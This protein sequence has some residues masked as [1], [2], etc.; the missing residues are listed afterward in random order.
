MGSGNESEV[1][2]VMLDKPAYFKK[3]ILLSIQSVFF[4][5]CCFWDL[6]TINNQH[7]NLQNAQ[8]N[9]NFWPLC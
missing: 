3:A 2:T 1:F 9:F 4:M 8:L 7:L 6:K 5:Y